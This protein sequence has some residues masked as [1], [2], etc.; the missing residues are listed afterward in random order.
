MTPDAWG[1]VGLVAAA[2]VAAG[3][4]AAVGRR[5]REGDERT[6]ELQADAGIASGY[7]LLTDDL[8]RDIEALRRHREEDRALIDGLRRDVDHVKQRYRN[9]LAYIR[10]L[11][12]FI[13]DNAPN[14]T[15]P[16]PPSDLTLDAD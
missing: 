2:I 11:L 3:G 6:Y 1:A 7:S 13:A 16:A 14:H 8:R 12:A 4:T 15:P 5:S 10:L 9:A